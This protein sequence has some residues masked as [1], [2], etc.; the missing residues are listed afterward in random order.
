MKNCTMHTQINI[1]I[2][3]IFVLHYI[4]IYCVHVHIVGFEFVFFLIATEYESRA[5]WFSVVKWL[6]Y[7]RQYVPLIK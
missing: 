2:L 3:I 5:I 6:M 1:A 4:Y 7:I